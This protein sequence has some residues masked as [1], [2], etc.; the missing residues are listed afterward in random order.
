MISA[1]PP[2]VPGQELLERECG[3]SGRRKH[4]DPI[5]Q[6]PD[7]RPQ[8]PDPDPGRRLDL[9]PVGTHRE[10]KV[11]KYSLSNFGWTY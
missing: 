5:P 9:D 6:T 4:P 8:T 11:S 10:Q 7:P 2:L 3:S 1:Y